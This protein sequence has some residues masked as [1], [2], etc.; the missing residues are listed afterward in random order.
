MEDF[1]NYLISNKY[2]MGV[3]FLRAFV[4]KK[5]S[6]KHSY[7][8][9]FLFSYDNTIDRLYVLC[10][11]KGTNYIIYDYSKLSES[12]QNNKINES[13]MELSQS[14]IEQLYQNISINK[15]DKK[16]IFSRQDQKLWDTFNEIK[17][18]LFTEAIKEVSVTSD[19][20]GSEDVIAN[21][22]MPI[23]YKLSIE[24]KNIIKN[25]KKEVS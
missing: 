9:H 17:E 13:M 18:D 25:K 6:A 7:H 22:N 16:Y 21:S 12:E 24:D 1:I 4:N 14:F 15:I 5:S 3:S 10:L 23:K 11:D 19:V 2:G 8:L 20:E